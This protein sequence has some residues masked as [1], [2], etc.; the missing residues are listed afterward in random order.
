MTKQQAAESVKYLEGK[1]FDYAL[2]QTWLDHVAYCLKTVDDNIYHK[3]L[4]NFVWLYDEE[5]NISG[6]PYP[7]TDE[8][9][10]IAISLL[11]L[12]SYR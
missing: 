2:P 4:G 12:I 9:K 7:I 8:G 5:A 10:D 1:T 11:Q 6:R 3:V